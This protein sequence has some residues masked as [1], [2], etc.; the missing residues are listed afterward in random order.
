MISRDVAVVLIGLGMLLFVIG[1]ALILANYGVEIQ[2]CSTFVS[3][4]RGFEGAFSLVGNYTQYKSLNVVSIHNVSIPAGKPYKH[5]FELK[6]LAVAPIIAYYTI[7]SPTSVNGY[8]LLKDASNST[9]DAIPLQLST[10][11]VSSFKLLSL[12]AL[13]P[14]K[15]YVEV[16]P[17]TNMT[18][19]SFNITAL[20]YESL[21]A[22]RITF[23]PTTYDQTSIQYVCGVS[24]RGLI[25]AAAL[26]GFGIAAISFVGVYLYRQTQ[27]TAKITVLAK[28]KRRTS[29]KK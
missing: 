7:T 26:I 3:M 25:I 1:W 6:S 22:I 8:V 2:T 5:W 17:L 18:L 13:S 12:N 15:Y 23:T 4:P 21:P 19:V 20:T 14:G 27:T 10:N 9:L 29:K 11:N 16:D 28:G 24:F